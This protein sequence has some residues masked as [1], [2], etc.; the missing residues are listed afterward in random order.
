MPTVVSEQIK[1]LIEL[2]KIDG[3]IY[4][5]KSELDLH[6]AAKA[7]AEAEF[8][9]KKTNMKAAEAEHKT[10]LVK[11]KDIENDLQSKED[12]IAKLSGQ[13]YQIKSNKE[14]SAMEME[15]KGAKADKSLIEEDILRHMDIVEAAK[16]KVAKEKELLSAEEKKFNEEVGSLKKKSD[17]LNVEISSRVEKRKTYVPNVDPPILAQYDRLL[18]GSRGH[19]LVPVKNNSCG[20][21]HLGLPPQLVNQIHMGEKIFFCDACARMLYWP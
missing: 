1:I 9:K 7:K 13:L 19:A 12:K 18:K 10:L 20:G 3:E 16:A 4:E 6:P 15:I 8:D 11:Q 2:Q 21:C 5:L 14:Y 17:D